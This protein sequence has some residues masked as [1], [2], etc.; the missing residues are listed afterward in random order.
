MPVYKTDE[1]LE[2][3][4]RQFLR[5]LGLENRRRGAQNR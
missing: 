4:G 5:Q 2:E 3:I 1:Q